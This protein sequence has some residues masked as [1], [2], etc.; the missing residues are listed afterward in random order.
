MTLPT[1]FCCFQITSR[2]PAVISPAKAPTEKLLVIISLVFLLLGYKHRLLSTCQHEQ[3]H[4]WPGSFPWRF[5][6][7]LARYCLW[8]SRLSDCK[9]PQ[10]CK[11]DRSQWE[12]KDMDCIQTMTLTDIVEHSSTTTGFHR[13][14]STLLNRI[15]FLRWQSA[16][17]GCHNR[18]EDSPQNSIGLNEGWT[19]YC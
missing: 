4:C 8:L 14:C 1:T 7:C 13:N 5:F 17:S 18:A 6:H 10:V 11:P 12:L 3:E 2:D 19:A 15:Y 16:C 9:H